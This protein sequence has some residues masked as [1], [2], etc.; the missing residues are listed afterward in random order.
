MARIVGIDLGTTN[1]LVAFMDGERPRIIPAA[2]GARMTPSVVGLDA[3]GRLLVGD[4]AK[5]Q[6]TVAPERTVAE[7][8]RLM[9]SAERVRLGERTYSP[10]EISALVLRAL[11][12]DAERFFG[13]A[14]DEAVVTVPA[15]FTDAQ[16][17]ATK[18][19]GQLAGL[20][21]DRILNEP[22]AAALAYGLDHL[23]KE[24]TVVVYDLGG[25]TFDVSVLE[26]YEGVL[27]VKASAGNNRLGGGDFDRSLADWIF[28]EMERTHAVDA[29]RDPRLRARVL[30]AAEEA[31]RQ[32]S[33]SEAAI[34]SLGGIA[35]RGGAPVSFEVEVSRRTLE[36]RIEPLV[37][38]TLESV[39][40]ALAD[41]KVEARGVAEVVLVGGSSRVPLVR[42]MVA[43]LF[44]KE[45]RRGVDPDEAVALGA[46]VQAGLKTGAISAQ[47][48]IMITDVCPFTL[49]VEVSAT[50]GS[51][52]VGGMFSP[53]IPRNSTVPVSRTE[54]YATAGDQ[55]RVV[56]V[57]VFQ[58]DARMVRNN[59][60]L[61]Q[62]TVEGIPPGPKGSQKVAITFSYDI[63]GIL[64]VTTK[65]L[66]TGK[67]ASITID[68]SPERMSIEERTSSAARLDREW[69]PG[70]PAGAAASTLAAP[71]PAAAPPAAEAAA[72]PEGELLAAGKRRL[73]GLPAA[74]A[75]E[76]GAVITALEQAMKAGDRAAV[77]R[78]EA[79]LTD[80]LF[81]L[82]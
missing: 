63:N 68:K 16:R 15:Y 18:D 42:R 12:E 81:A 21:V 1:S 65:V 20:R 50:A 66:S 79:R 31:K 14:V 23:D 48:G 75:A 71:T 28:E 9:G 72:A 39:R 73:A 7:V 26:M 4:A 82:E 32:L 76:L 10:T 30:S 6:L 19:A 45:P 78:H 13:E 27:E 22:T 52:I 49:G 69:A 43:E 56:E 11:K 67:E 3:R 58:G 41:A 2:T 34:V 80:V 51:Q 64:Q 33:G 24:Q 60:F 35:V 57:R 54:I 40:S 62:Y 70:R 17:Q 61:G 38:S 25:G 59:V 74:Q 37:R 47:T 53:I 5:G 36:E 29:R 44:G 77:A 8:K 55:Q 46:A